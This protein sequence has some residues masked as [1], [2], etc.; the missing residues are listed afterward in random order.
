MNADSLSLLIDIGVS[1]AVALIGWE[2]IPMNTPDDK[3]EWWSKLQP[4][5]K[6]G[7][8]IATLIFT[9]LFFTE[10]AR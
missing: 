7:G 3:K 4:V 2:I 6:W 8:T 5:L 9:A 10:L 1:L